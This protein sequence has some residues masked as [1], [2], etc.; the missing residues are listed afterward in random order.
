MWSTEIEDRIN[1]VIVRILLEGRCIG[2]LQLD[3]QDTHNIELWKTKVPKFLNNES[4]L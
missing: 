2:S 3:S 1:H 4:S